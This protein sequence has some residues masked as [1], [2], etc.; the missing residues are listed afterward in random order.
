MVRSGSHTGSQ[1]SEGVA[2]PS[3]SPSEVSTDVNMFKVNSFI[4][5]IINIVSNIDV[6]QFIPSDPVSTDSNVFFFFFFCM[7]HELNVVPKGP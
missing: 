6:N 2:K 7:R 4:S 5:G 3:V 1:T